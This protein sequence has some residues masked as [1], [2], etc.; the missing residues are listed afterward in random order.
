MYNGFMGRKATFICL[1]FIIIVAFAVRTYN[2]SSVPPSPYLDEVTNGYNAYSL[3]KTGCDEYARHLPLILQAYNDYRPALFEYYA[4]PFIHFFGLTLFAIRLPSVLLGVMTT[5]SMFFLAK[6]ILRNKP[7][8]SKGGTGTVIA[9][10][11]AFLYAISPWNIYCSRISDEINMSLSFFA[12]SLTV[13]LY[14][15]NRFRERKGVI[16]FFLSIVLFE[17]CFYTYNGVKLFIPF[18]LISLG[19]IYFQEF[20]RRKKLAIAGLIFGFVLLL[21]LILAF[22]SPENAVRFNSVNTISTDATVIATSAKRVLYDRLLNDRLGEVFDNRRV[23]ISLRFLT[24][25]IRNFDPSW[26]F[27]A[28]GGKS[29]RVPDL[30][31][32]YLFQFPLLLAGIYFLSRT[33]AIQNK[34]KWVIFLSIILSSIP[35]GFNSESPHLNRTNTMLPG[36]T[37]ISALGLYQCL[38]VTNRLKNLFL[39]RTLYVG[40]GAVIVIS[41][42][43]FCHTYFVTFPYRE[44][45][46]YQY[47]ATQALRYADARK[48][49]YEKIVVSNGNALLEGYMYYLFATQY[50]PK[51]YQEAGG[52]RTAFY[53]DT[54]LIG[55][56]DFRDPNMV[57]SEVNPADIGKPILYITNVGELDGRT[58]ERYHLTDIET[59][60]LPDGT[61]TIVLS[62]GTIK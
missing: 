20:W 11:A 29:W 8:A 35:A 40:I 3:L 23:L 1:L 19:I 51:T 10:L 53:T 18:F 7:S 25:S 54:H 59:F 58:R 61:H 14:A 6:E 44:A 52:T 45:A 57:P 38:L 26:L 13:F 50:D 28:T 27:F 17:I 37:I 33:N 49:S 48:D 46:F 12:F 21:P 43:W 41:F 2:L 42:I 39:K 31:P 30:G 56:F 4:T 24:N 9:L 32:L 16:A 55:K 22:R 62:E 15:M 34:V 47:G 36:L 5:L 60:S